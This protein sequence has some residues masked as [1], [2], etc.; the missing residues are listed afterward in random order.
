MAMAVPLPS[1]TLACYLNTIKF[2][3]RIS[4]NVSMT[5]RFCNLSC[6][7]SSDRQCRCVSSMLLSMSIASDELR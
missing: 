4:A 6:L 7:T 1:E 2:F 5:A 3:S